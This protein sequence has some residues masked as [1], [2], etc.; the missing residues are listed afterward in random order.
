MI[1]I[2]VAGLMLAAADAPSATAQ[3]DPP[4]EAELSADVT[5]DGRVDHVTVSGGGDSRR[6]IVKA[7]SDAGP[8]QIGSVALS[9]DSLMNTDLEMRD[10]VLLVGE[11]SG[12]TTAVSSLYRYRY[13]PAVRRMRLIGDDVTVYSRTYAHGM[14]EVSTNRLTG[15]RTTTRSELAPKSFAPQA[16]RPGR[17]TRSRV[18]RTPI[19]MEDS[20]DPWQTVGMGD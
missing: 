3:S 14:T 9:E 18:S 2:F 20:P 13:D 11:L 15:Q 10:G 1:S 17:V 8:I 12:G 5:G 7:A 4:I 6:L 16:Y 19:W